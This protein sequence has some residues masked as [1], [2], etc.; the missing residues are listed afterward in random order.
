MSPTLQGIAEVC[1]FAECLRESAKAW[2]VFGNNGR[3]PQQRQLL[4][5]SPCG[6]PGT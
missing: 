2:A 1:Q 4:D 3:A 6:F 5:G